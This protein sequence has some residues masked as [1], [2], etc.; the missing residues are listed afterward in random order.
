[1]RLRPIWKAMTEMSAWKK[2][3]CTRKWPT[4]ESLP[5][6]N[7]FGILRAESIETT[8]LLINI[9]RQLCLRQWFTR[10]TWAYPTRS[11]HL[12]WQPPSRKTCYILAVLLP[13]LPKT[14]T[15][16]G[17][18]AYEAVRGAKTYGHRQT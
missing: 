1:M 7:I 5:L 12:V 8:T 2:L 18:A 9:R 10:C 4:E 11:R 13:L 16:N 6:I 14:A 3:P 17:M 15:S